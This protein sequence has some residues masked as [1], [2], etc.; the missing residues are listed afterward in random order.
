MRIWMPIIETGSG[1]DVYF[2]QLASGLRKLGHS[3]YL[4][5]FAHRYELFPAQISFSPPPNL[6]IIHSNSWCAFAF[7]VEGVPLVTTVHH[8]VHDKSYQQF[9]SISQRI[10]H[11]TLIKKFECKSFQLADATVAVSDFT[12]Q[13][14]TNTFPWL[15]PVM[16]YNGIDTNVFKPEQVVASS[17]KVPVFKIFS[18]ANLS[19]RKAVE[20][21]PS[22]LDELGPDFELY[23]TGGMRGG[24]PV[25]RHPRLHHT[26]F[27]DNIALLTMYQKS[28]AFL[29]M[30]RFEG[31]GLS[32]AEAMACGLPCVVSRATAFPELVEDGKTGVLCEVDDVIGFSNAL[33]KLREDNSFALSLGRNARTR[34]VNE[35]DVEKML[36]SY[37]ELYLSKTS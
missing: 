24:K 21:Y 17:D 30:S 36:A 28:N 2:E 22:L 37:E 3:V 20:L 4:D 25:F 27:L 33:K 34:V 26:G 16:I 35:F 5:K 1:S 14:V 15:S 18:V 23:V 29:S 12:A 10:Y 6:D 11:R 31:F 7:Q 13:S 9:C 8:N 32:L 19:N